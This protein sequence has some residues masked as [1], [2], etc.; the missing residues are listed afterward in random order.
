MARQRAGRRR[1]RRS[2]SS[3]RSTAEPPPAAPASASRFEPTTEPRGAASWPCAGSS[4]SCSATTST[5]TRAVI[6][7]APRRVLRPGARAVAGEHRLL[8]L[9][10]DLRALT[11]PRH[12]DG[13][14]RRAAAQPAGAPARLPALA[15]RRGRGPARPLRRAPRARRSPTTA[16]TSL[17]R[18]AGARGRLLPAVPRRSSAPAPPRA[19]VLAILDRRLERR[20]AGRHVD[21]DF[22]DGARPPR[23][24]A[25]TA[26]SRRSPTSPA[27]CA[28]AA[29]T[30]R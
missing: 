15:R 3:S 2:C 23:G 30:S 21:D 20:R 13:R 17:D 7:D 27:R 8:E 10:A 12:D 24:H 9:F 6:A 19:A 14:R 25:A 1:Q 4:G 28:S 26:A 11:R 29:S 5:P 16:S 18:T 22:R